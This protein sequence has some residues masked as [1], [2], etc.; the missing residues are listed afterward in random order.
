[1]KSFHCRAASGGA[2]YIA[3]IGA[4]VMSQTNIT[5]NTFYSNAATNSRAHGG[6]GALYLEGRVTLMN[7]SA[8]KQNNASGYGGALVYAQACFTSESGM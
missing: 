1:M 2:A 7:G 4:S 5:N 3:A 6:G 8:F